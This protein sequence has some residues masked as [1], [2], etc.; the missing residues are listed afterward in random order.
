MTSW[1]G[2]RSQKFQNL[3]RFPLQFDANS[4]FSQFPVFEI[5]LKGPEAQ[6]S[7][8]TVHEFWRGK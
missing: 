7:S 1:P 3:K 5:H 4:V 2:L 6:S 8:W